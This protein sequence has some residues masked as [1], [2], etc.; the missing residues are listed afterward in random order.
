MNEKLKSALYELMSS[1]GGA[2]AKN[3]LKNMDVS[4][5]ENKI[6][7]MDKQAVINKL[8]SMNLGIIAD[9]IK[10]MTDQQLIDIIKSNPHFL[11]MINRL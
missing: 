5:I 9:R 11:D 2:K 10:N 3:Q 6:A 7:S 8:Y 4:D 1:S